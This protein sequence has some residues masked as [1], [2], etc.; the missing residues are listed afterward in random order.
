VYNAFHRRA[1]DKRNAA[2]LGSTA[3]AGQLQ[4]ELPGERITI[5][6]SLDDL[7]ALAG[8]GGLDDRILSR[9]LR[10]TFDCV[11]LPMAENVATIG[12][13][14]SGA[15]PL[16][17]VTAKNW[18]EAQPSTASRY[19]M[20]VVAARDA[21]KA[22]A[23]ALEDMAAEEAARAS[24]RAGML[25]V[26]PELARA[27]AAAGDAAAVERAALMEEWYVTAER[28]PPAT[29]HGTLF[30]TEDEAAARAK[31]RAQQLQLQQSRRRA[32]QL[33]PASVLQS[34]AHPTCWCA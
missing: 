4:A 18:R 15:V 25:A 16:E 9:F 23:A 20:A 19:S 31:R 11:L 10:R 13:V 30:D 34:L 22:R 12:C 7:T 27:L 3:G 24:F 6:P 17:A 32:A 1:A 29:S 14:R 26:H 8:G 5:T 33:P 21:D 2:P 28:A